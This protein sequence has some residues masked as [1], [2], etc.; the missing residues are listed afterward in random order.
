MLA[1]CL[2]FEVI[3]EGVETEAQFK[4]LEELKSDAV[5]GY[6]LARL[7]SPEQ[8]ALRFKGLSELPNQ[9]RL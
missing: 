8:V 9:Q 6:F 2:S 5:H 7:E 1:D 4:L 3:A